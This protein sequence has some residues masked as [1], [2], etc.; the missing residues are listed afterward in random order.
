[1]VPVPANIQAYI[2]SGNSPNLSYSASHDSSHK[3]S[4]KERCSSATFT[5][6]HKYRTNSPTHKDKYS[7]SYTEEKTKRGKSKTISHLKTK[8][9]RIL[10]TKHKSESWGLDRNNNNFDNCYGDEFR[11]RDSK[12]F[13]NSHSRYSSFDSETSSNFSE[14][15]EE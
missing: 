11:S 15:K 12:V 14:L 8:I 4:P 2:Q 3:G 13:Q 10:K 5:R 7:H 1:M 9:P 6:E